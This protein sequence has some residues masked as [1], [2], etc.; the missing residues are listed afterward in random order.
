MK[1]VN[2]GN[3]GWFVSE[4]SLGVMRMNS[5]DHSQAEK[6]IQTSLENGID[7]FDHADIYGDGESEKIF[8]Q[9]FKNLGIKRDSVSL[10]SKTGIV[11]GKMYDFSKSHII[12]SV[13][14]SL[15]RLQTDYLDT[16][17]LHR[18]DTLFEP[19][20]VAEAFD[21]LEKSGKVLHFGVSNQ[22][23]MQI[24]LLKKYV[25][26]PLLINQLQLSVTHHP[27]IDA[28]FNV[29]T[30][31]D[32]AST[33]DGSILEYS[34]INDMT[35]Q[36]W[37]PF[38]AGMQKEGLFFD[39]P[40]F[41]ELNEV[42]HRLASEKSVAREAI[43]IAWLLRHPAHMQPIIGSM[44]PERIAAICEA[45]NITLSREEWYEVYRSGDYPIP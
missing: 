5:L 8:G 18:P 21:E 23:P 15:M 9:A 41:V 27:M 30:S 2:L 3:S 29:N 40:D 17:L 24:E 16:L 26:Q 37:S 7:Y 13:E 25:T 42:L 34:R 32:F 20:E 6:V 31:N 38:Q 36:P 45:S 4:I 14:E 11:K 1:K 33:R 39:H 43:A 22:N 35:I 44:N 28:G 10:Q 12:K 19:E